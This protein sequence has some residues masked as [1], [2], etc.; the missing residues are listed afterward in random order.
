MT[1][2]KQQS[3]VSKMYSGEVQKSSIGRDTKKEKRIKGRTKKPNSFILFLL[4]SS[5]LMNKLNDK[6]PPTHLLI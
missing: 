4:C 3:F 5:V 6:S 2:V 1:D